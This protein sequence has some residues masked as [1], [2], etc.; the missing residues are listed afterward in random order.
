MRP[1]GSGHNQEE[2]AQRYYEALMKAIYRM[3][4]IG[5]IED[6]TQ[7]YNDEEFRIVA[8]KLS[9]GEYYENLKSFLIRYFSEDR[10][11]REIE[12][13]K[14]YR[15]ENEIQKC[16]GYLT[17][18]I[19]NS[20]ATKRKQS[21]QDI[22]NLCNRAASSDNSWLE[23]NEELKDDIYYYF[24]SKYAR[25]EFEAPNGEQFS[26]VS[27]TSE[28]RL[29]DFKHVIKYM[30]VIDDDLI[31]AGGTP[32]DNIK[33]LLGAV[34][35]IRRS[36]TDSN[37][38]LDFLNVFCLYYLQVN[39]T[40]T[41]LHAELIQ[42]YIDGY[43]SFRER[44]NVLNDNFYDCINEFKNLM[45]EKR[46]INSQQRKELEELELKVEA[47]VHSSW[48]SQFSSHFTK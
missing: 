16:L 22:E 35:L 26:L 31:A 38:T 5:L 47:S 23:V 41:L 17:D 34:R 4:C 37:P 28:G 30:R 45:N 6:Y 11:A 19:Y 9:S 7:N 33:H 46:I 39:K 29:F 8:R 15:G 20:I 48:L 12:K 24:N 21:I 18:F 32:K 3:C 25:R 10:A 1:I 42:S 13:A 43:S 40:E 14:S 44:K 2:R 27:D 36:L